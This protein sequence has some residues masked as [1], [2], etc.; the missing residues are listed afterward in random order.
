M[1][2]KS[3]DHPTSASATFVERQQRFPSVGPSEQ[4][5]DW[6]NT[7]L[8]RRGVSRWYHDRSCQ[9]MWSG[10]G[11]TPITANSTHDRCCGLFILHDCAFGMPLPI[12]PINV[13]GAREYDHNRKSTI[14]PKASMDT[15]VHLQ[16]HSVLGN[17]SFC[18]IVHLQS[19]SRIP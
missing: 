3:H 6:L 14:A 1:I 16:C 7:L 10:Q 8:F 15:I 19:H 18:T 13:I 11:D 5:L 2:T 4:G 9:S 17:L 12:V